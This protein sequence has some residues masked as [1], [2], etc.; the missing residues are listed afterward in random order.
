MK[1][2]LIVLMGLQGSGKSSKA[3]ELKE[4]M[5]NTLI[6]SSDDLRK[7]LLGDR[8]NQEQNDL[9]FREM[10]K[11]TKENLQN[12]I[13]V[14]YDATNINSRRRIALLRGLP[15]EVEKILYFINEKYI[16]SC[17]NDNNR[18]YSVGKD[19]I[20]KTYK[21]LQVP[22]THEKWDN[23][24]VDIGSNKNT[25]VDCSEQQ[26]ILSKMTEKL[27]SYEE[28]VRAISNGSLSYSLGNMLNICQDNPHHTFTIDKHTYYV[29]EYIFKKYQKEDREDLIIA[30]LFHDVGKPFCKEY[31][32]GLR[33]ARYFGHE[34]VGGQITLRELI[35]LGYSQE[36]ALKIA[37][38]VGLHMRMSFSL[39]MMADRK[40]EKLVGEETFIK[41]NYL[42]Q[43]DIQAK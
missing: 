28:F 35:K 20:S 5:T 12:G 9:I 31:P 16:T 36:R 1:T 41:L 2:K 4:K 14:I 13:N 38:L 33:Y 39:D 22:Y 27:F 11:R 25:Y 17:F 32:S 40:L 19:C 26:E 6:I 42:R 8:R 15:K 7:E 29:Y 34:N 21:G 37:S 43:A 23:I 3:F 30:S 24:I 18:E 10:H